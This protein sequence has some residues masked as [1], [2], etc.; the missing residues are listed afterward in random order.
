M[1]SNCASISKP[2]AQN[3]CGWLIFKLCIFKAGLALCVE[4]SRGCLK[5]L[6]D[7]LD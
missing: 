1:P 4:K 7:N 6:D 5:R 3:V 2:T